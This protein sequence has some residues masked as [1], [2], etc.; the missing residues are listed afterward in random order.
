MNIFSILSPHHW[1]RARHEPVSHGAVDVQQSNKPHTAASQTAASFGKVVS[2]DRNNHTRVSDAGEAYFS[3]RPV[4]RDAAGL[5]KFRAGLVD[6]SAISVNGKP[7]LVR[8]RGFGFEDG[9]KGTINDRPLAIYQKGAF[10]N[11][12]AP[13]YRIDLELQ[14]KGQENF[15]GFPLTSFQ[16]IRRSFVARDPASYSVLNQPYLYADQA[17]RDASFYTR[18]Q[19]V[20]P[21]TTEQILPRNPELLRKTIRET[22]MRSGRVQ[23]AEAFY[24]AE[25]VKGLDTGQIKG[26]RD[27]RGHRYPRN[28][29]IVPG[30]VDTD[31][32]TKLSSECRWAMYTD[33]K[34]TSVFKQRNYELAPKAER[35]QATEKPVAAE[36]AL[37]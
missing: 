19:K 26:L 22:H 29:V 1:A 20:R 31:K 3:R 12:F 11:P 33:I 8:F 36:K 37:S 4:G 10:P 9:K 16:E 35:Q 13:V 25:S 21:T 17:A 34:P 18:W 32:I 27:S 14:Q 7:Q 2:S 30:S 24:H 5:Q 15:N 23:R 28:V 6:K